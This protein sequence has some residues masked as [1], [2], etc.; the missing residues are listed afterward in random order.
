MK[1]NKIHQSL[2]LVVMTKKLIFTSVDV[3]YQ[4]NNE[5]IQIWT[6]ELEYHERI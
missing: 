3:I 1:N 6:P 2:D 5:G 4:S